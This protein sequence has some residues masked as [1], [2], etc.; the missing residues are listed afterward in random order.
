MITGYG[1][2]KS[3]Y[4]KRKLKGPTDVGVRVWLYLCL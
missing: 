2:I 3:V 1:M 4:D